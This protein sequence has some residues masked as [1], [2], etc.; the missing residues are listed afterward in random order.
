MP[1]DPIPPALQALAPFVGTWHTTGTVVATSA[2]YTATDIYE[3]L[4]GRHF[5]LHR[6]DAAMPEGRSQGI[7]V[8]GADDSEGKGGHYTLRSFDDTGKEDTLRAVVDGKAVAFDGEEVRFR[9]AFNGDETEMSG[10]WSLQADGSQ[11][12]EPWMTVSLRRSA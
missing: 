6:W 2:P 11:G 7:E 9:G 5:L 8:I 12:W 10:T 3:W 1:I 4:P